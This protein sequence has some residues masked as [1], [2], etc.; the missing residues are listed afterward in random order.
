[1]DR[2][3]PPRPPTVVTYDPFLQRT[4]RSSSSI[5][6]SITYVICVFCAPG[7]SRLTTSLLVL[8]WPPCSETSSLK[9]PTTGRFQRFRGYPL[10]TRYYCSID[11][12]RNLSARSRCLAFTPRWILTSILEVLGNSKH[13][14]FL[15]IILSFHFFFIFVPCSQRLNGS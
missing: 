13:M 9:T 2:F 5:F 11:Y 14:S 6:F 3:L 4:E 15:A 1:M 7:A 12:T 8:A 10:I